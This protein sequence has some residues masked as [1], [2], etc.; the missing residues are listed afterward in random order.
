MQSDAHILNH[1]TRRLSP[2]LSLN[3]SYLDLPWKF[4]RESLENRFLFHCTSDLTGK[5]DAGLELAD[6]EVFW[7]T[8]SPEEAMSQLAPNEVGIL[9]IISTSVYEERVPA[10][11]V[12]TE[13]DVQRAID[14]GAKYAYYI[15]GDYVKYGFSRQAVSELFEKGNPYEKEG[16]YKAAHRIAAIGGEDSFGQ[17]H[18]SKVLQT[19]LDGANYPPSAVMDDCYDQLIE[20]CNSFKDGVM[21]IPYQ[22][23]GAYHN[24]NTEKKAEIS[25][26]VLTHPSWHK[27]LY[28]PY[29]GG[30]F[31]NEDK[32]HR[33]AVRGILSSMPLFPEFTVTMCAASESFKK[34]YDHNESRYVNQSCLRPC[35]VN[36]FLDQWDR[37]YQEIA[38]YEDEIRRMLEGC[39]V[40]PQRP[41]P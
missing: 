4:T 23:T 10:I 26:E 19:V 31:S 6:G 7:A 11:E 13:A 9:S 12:R 20:Q 17:W 28:F 15:D 1:Q 22:I 25:K 27:T 36:E 30:S 35:T 14:Q 39:S 2:Q 29:M 8:N 40:S 21:R 16:L 38:D 41:R 33:E 24:R 32:N 3:D 5:R 34:V 37:M 18:Y